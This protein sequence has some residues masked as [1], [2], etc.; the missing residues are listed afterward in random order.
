MNNR[1]SGSKMQGKTSG[2][3]R[4][5]IV[6]VTCKVV[7][8]ILASKFGVVHELESPGGHALEPAPIQFI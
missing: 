7:S 4:V 3:A 8:N 2:C 6:L 5:P 1:S